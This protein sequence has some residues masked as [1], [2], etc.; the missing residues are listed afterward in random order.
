MLTRSLR[1]LAALASLGVAA[2]SA[3]ACAT[4]DGPEADGSDSALIDKNQPAMSKARLDAI[5]A[6]GNIKTLDAL[7]AALPKDFLVNVTLKHGKLRE[8]E[9]GH[10]VERDVSQSS[11]PLAPRAIVWDERSGFTVSYNGAAPGQTEGQR[12]DVL[13]FDDAA[14]TFHLSGLQF[15]GQRAPV[16]QTDAQIP[17][18][19][20]KCARCHGPSMRPIFSMY[21][22]WPSFY[23]SDNDELTDTSKEV[24]ALELRDFTA[25][26]RAVDATRAPR[27]APLFDRDAIKTLL[28]GTELYP[29]FPYRQD[30]NTAIRAVSRAFAFRPSLRFGILM[31]RLMAESAGRKITQHQAWDKFGPLFLHGLLE[32]RFQDAGALASTGW[33]DAVKSENGAAPRTV[34]GGRTL[35]YRD[36]LKLFD[37]EVKDIDIRYSYN[38]AGYANEDATNKVMEVGYIDGTYWNSYFDGSAT[39]DELLAMQ[40]FTALASKPAFQGLPASLPE[41]NGLEHKYDH[42]TERFAFDKNFFQE[43][44]KKSR[45]IPIPY[46]RKLTDVHHREG[47]PQSYASQHTAVCGALEAQL[48]RGPGATGGGSSG[49][50]SATVCPAGCVASSYCKDHP[51]ASQAVKVGG[52]PCMKSGA[53]GC[54]AC[55]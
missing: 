24:Q 39:I 3:A 42:L 22:D 51:N 38:H 50:G 34:A 11:D 6:R 40:L 16:Y 27:Y 23:G 41:P 37:L 28:R 47:F 36:L 9:R 31:N 32:C 21:P 17:E 33:A 12:L 18:A 14:K 44:D 43:M 45:W 46:P 19:S 35:H 48:L 8:G 26:R 53:G 10:L 25:F 5:V 29:T 52:L 15:D 7:P 55:R 4:E 20:R 49:G 1:T 13:E 54:Q 30:T 2:T